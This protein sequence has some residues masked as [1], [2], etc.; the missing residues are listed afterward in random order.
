[1]RQTFVT[2]IVFAV[3]A[4]LLGCPPTNSLLKSRDLQAVEVGYVS[5]GSNDKILHDDNAVDQLA[6]QVTEIMLFNGF[7]VSDTS[8]SYGIQPWTGHTQNVYFQ[9]AGNDRVTC[10]TLYCQTSSARAE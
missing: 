5:D 4:G 3:C 8:V 10:R 2:L 7:E 1:M 9:L 6:T